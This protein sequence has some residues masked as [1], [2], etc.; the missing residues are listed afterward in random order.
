MPNYLFF[1]ES[2]STLE[3]FTELYDFVWPTA[4]AMWNLRWQVGGFVGAVPSASDE[5]LLSRFAD[6][7]MIHGANLRRACVERGWDD[8]QEQFASMLLINS[9]SLF[10]SWV[11]GVLKRIGKDSRGRVKGLQFPSSG[12]DGV[13][14]AVRS[15]TTPESPALKAAFY[16]GLTSHR[17]NRRAKLDELLTC[18]RY[19]KECRNCLAHNGGLASREA[20]DAYRDFA[21]VATVARLGVKEVPKHAALVEGEVVRL[22]LRGVVGFTD[23]VLRIV[24]TLDAELSRAKRA[25]DVFSQYWK[26][27]IGR[28]QTLKSDRNAR[29]SQVQ[30]LCAKLELPRPNQTD[31]IERL[32]KSKR[33][34]R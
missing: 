20:A 10:E 30:R 13:W 11:A 27:A 28:G 25:E 17:K 19:F 24:T 12:R 15:A 26:S 6:G 22:Y 21:S 5:L 7:A 33:L 32:I 2:R 16:A 4:V 14:P 23:V 8:Q 1:L 29:K 9:C 18:Y 31:E 34:A 3:R